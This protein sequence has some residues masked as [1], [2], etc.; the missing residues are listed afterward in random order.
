MIEA[1]V[2]EKQDDNAVGN[3]EDYKNLFQNNEE[4]LTNEPNWLHLPDEIWLNILGYLS[5]NELA[6]FGLTCKKFQKLYVDGTLWKKI[7]M[8]YQY[9]MCDEWLNWIGKRRPNELN[10]VQCSGIVSLNAIAEMFKKI[11]NE[12]QVKFKF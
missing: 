8:K 3:Q 11:G 2:I 9:N 6:Q 7:S 4:D 12:L 1:K 5:Q 10:I